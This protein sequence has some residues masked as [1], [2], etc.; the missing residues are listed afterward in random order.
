MNL[1]CQIDEARPEDACAVADI[2]IVSRREAMPYLRPPHSD[3]ETLEWFRR[4]VGDPPG[5]WWVARH[6]ER[7][8]GYMLLHGEDLAHLYVLPDLQR[9]GIGDALLDKA[10]ELSPRGL[11][12][13][14]FERNA[15]ALA[16]YEASGF[17]VVGRT[18][19][20]NE[21]SDPDVQYAW[22]ST[23]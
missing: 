14:T 5:A 23:P 16:F 19:G 8:V 20:C 10:K 9:S 6:A 2:H 18:D 3:T 11:V 17:R 1:T 4:V 21:E 13:W 22:S 12:L 15:G 7:V